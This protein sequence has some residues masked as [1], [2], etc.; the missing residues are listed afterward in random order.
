MY[1]RRKIKVMLATT[2]VVAVSAMANAQTH[3]ELFLFS[4]T[5]L[6]GNARFVSMG[7]AFGGLGANFGTASTNP[8]GIGF[9]TRNELSLTMAV[10]SRNSQ[11]KYNDKSRSAFDISFQIPNL[12]YVYS[13]SDAR[14]Q[15]GVGINRLQDFNSR[16]VIEG[17]TDYSFTNMIAA[18]TN[19]ILIDKLYDQLYS[20]T[21]GLEALAYDALLTEM[22]DTVKNLYS[23][24]LD[25]LK[26]GQI[27]N[28][29]QITVT[30]GGIT[31]LAF[32]FAG[33]LSEKFYFG[34][35]IGVP[36]LSY[37]EESTLTEVLNPSGDFYNLGIKD[38]EYAH[39]YRVNGAGINLK[40]GFVFKPINAVRIGLAFH[41]PTYYSL[42]QKLNREIWSNASSM[43]TIINLDEYGAGWN[44][45]EYYNWQETDFKYKYF[46]PAKG[47]LSLGF[48]IGNY[49]VIGVEGELMSYRSTRVVSDYDI[50]DD[51]NEEM[52]SKYTRV[53]GVVKVGTEWRINMFSLRAG[54][55]YRSN[56]YMDKADNLW[57]EHLVTGGLGIR[58]NQKVSLDLG[59]LYAFNPETYY[60][61]YLDTPK[62]SVLP[63]DIN[64]NKMLYTA[65]L[66]IRF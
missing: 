17:N 7:G 14:F 20:G 37:K 6:S 64:T 34:A 51:I 33:N 66:N 29:K 35:T 28:Q 8:A 63:D 65:S 60:P 61:Y 59:V 1:I 47:L 9:Y 58:F 41:T 31:E 44:Y 23:S 24:N 42:T 5:N 53:S 27:I 21:A 54:Y 25:V 12:H 32:T 40:L 57:S 11:T 38:W 15:F 43:D 2:I 56:P 39:D 10:N 52:R 26:V 62:T 3:Q 18:N 45:G 50:V 48:V 4:Q 13:T 36:I 19:G 16:T 49:G 22:T 30:S 46:T 55:N